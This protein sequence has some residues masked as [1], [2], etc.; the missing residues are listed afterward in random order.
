VQE[1]GALDF[2]KHAKQMTGL[3]LMPVLNLNLLSHE[4]DPDD[5]ENCIDANKLLI[6]VS[7]H[8]HLRLILLGDTLYRSRWDDKKK[9]EIGINRT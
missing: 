7:Q 1:A 9:V 3:R 8:Q 4:F 2:V 5:N 6:A